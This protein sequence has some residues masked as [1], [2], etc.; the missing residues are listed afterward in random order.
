MQ[1]RTS[2]CAL[3]GAVLRASQRE[4]MPADLGRD[5]SGALQSLKLR[6]CSGWALHSRNAGLS[7]FD[8][9]WPGIGKRHSIDDA[10]AASNVLISTPDFDA[11][12]YLVKGLIRGAVLS[13]KLKKHCPRRR[14]RH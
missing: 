14:S 5:L 7:G 4:V 9:I 3:K 2:A 13:S 8:A 6:G 10:L 1:S 11:V 12:R